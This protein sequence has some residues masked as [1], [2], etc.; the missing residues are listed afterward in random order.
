MKLLKFIGAFFTEPKFKI[1]WAAI[2]LAMLINLIVTHATNTATGWDI[3]LS[4]WDGLLAAVTYTL[5][6]FDA[7]GWWYRGRV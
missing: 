6:I 7:A 4:G 5:F 2:W 3:N 1:Y